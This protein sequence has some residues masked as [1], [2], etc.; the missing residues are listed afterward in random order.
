MELSLEIVTLIALIFLVIYSIKIWHWRC[1]L[2]PGFYFG[3][4]WT[5]GVLGARIFLEYGFLEILAEKYIIELN[6]FVLFTAVCF[7]F[8]TWRSR[9]KINRNSIVGINLLDSLLWFKILSCIVLLI[10]IYTF[11][12]AG[13]SFDMGASRDAM[14]DNVKNQSVFTGYGQALAIPLS[15]IGGSLFGK[16]L[17]KQVKLSWINKLF[18]FIPLLANLLFSIYLGG[19]VN[20]VYGF[21]QYG[22]GFC[23]NLKINQG[24]AVSK[25]IF[26]MAF[27]ALIVLSTFISIVAAQRQQ[28]QLGKTIKYDTIARQGTLY[29]IFYGPMEYMTSTY[30]GY[31]YRRID[32]V[33]EE[34]LTYGTRTFNGFINWSLPF[35][36]RFGLQDFTIADAFDVRYD[37]QETYDFKR[38][39]FYVTHSCYIPLVKDFGPTGT[40]FAIIFLTWIANYLFVKIQ[41]RKTIRWASSI[42]LYYIFLEYWLKSNYYGT[43]SGSIIVTL[44]GLLIFDL[45]NYISRKSYNTTTFTKLK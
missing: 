16:V 13:A 24:F 27:I 35:A 6:S 34:D 22:I 19:R 30:L 43:L 17:L 29:A 21:I 45:I 32:A 33:D 9:K 12:N 8:F 1:F 7:I 31:Q 26:K 18:L 10:A 39:F 3:F 42:F 23:L 25:R 5:F 11:I 4:I 44:Y 38:K 41:K 14:H 20:F 15:I 37:N 28:H 40:Y 36:S 2:S